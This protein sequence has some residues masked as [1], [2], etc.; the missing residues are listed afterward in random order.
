M[1]KPLIDLEIGKTYGV[2]GVQLTSTF[3]CEFSMSAVS[4]RSATALRW[5]IAFWFVLALIGQ[6]LFAL[7]ICVEFGGKLGLGSL[8]FFKQDNFYQQ[9]YP[10][11]AQLLL[12]M[13]VSL[14]AAVNVLGI[15]Q[16]LPKLRQW[17]PQWHRWNGRFFLSVGLV[18]AISGLYLSWGSGARM[19]NFGAI[20][21][22]FNGLL[23]LLI[24][25]L[26]WYYAW[27]RNF[28]MHRRL[29]V[30]AFML[31]S[32]VWFFRLSIMAWYLINQGPRGNSAKLDGPA[33]IF[34]SFAC[35]LLPMALAELYFWAERKKE[36]L[37][38]WIAASVLMLASVLMAVG[39]AGAAMFM[40]LPRMG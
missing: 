20:G 38:E 13:H 40:W 36:V 21:I 23:I 12:L 9:T 31:V 3:R 1:R 37:A 2:L 29:A 16:L 8:D 19:S 6:W 32:G 14:A 10:I 4:S 24:A 25:P 15:F 22:T 30:H 7:Y 27:R 33:D 18:G 34:L 5:S 11:T 39:I 17:K 35:Y 26:A 28:A